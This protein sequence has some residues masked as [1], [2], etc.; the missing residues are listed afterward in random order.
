MMKL[1]ELIPTKKLLIICKYLGIETFNEN[2]DVEPYLKDDSDYFML[3][4][5]CSTKETADYW[6]NLWR[7]LT[8]IFSTVD[9]DEIYVRISLKMMLTTLDLPL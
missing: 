3:F 2:Q 7:C 1:K 5:W 9:I 8:A 6:S 4:D